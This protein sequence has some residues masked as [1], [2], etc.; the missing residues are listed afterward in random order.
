MDRAMGMHL[1][2]ISSREGFKQRMHVVTRAV[3]FPVFFRRR[4]I[5]VIIC[6][7]RHLAIFFIVKIK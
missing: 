1:R 3:V 6:R 2:G 7:F 4:R 5:A